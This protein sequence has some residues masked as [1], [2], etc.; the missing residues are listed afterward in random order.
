MMSLNGREQKSIERYCRVYDMTDRQATV[1]FLHRKGLKNYR[2]ARNLGITNG[3][4]RNHL[5]KAKR[6]REEVLENRS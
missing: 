3:T 2:I 6:K 4:V 5:N 1:Y